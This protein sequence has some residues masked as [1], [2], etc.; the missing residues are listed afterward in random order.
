MQLEEWGF[1]FIDYN[2]LDFF[3]PRNIKGRTTLVQH[4]MW[5]LTQQ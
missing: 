1:W 5:E 4:M 3:R 2:F